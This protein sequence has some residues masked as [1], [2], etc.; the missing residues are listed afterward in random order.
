MSY[1]AENKKAF[2]DYEILEKIEAGLS[3]T[4]QETKSAKNGQVSLK[5]AFVTFHGP[6]AFITNMNIAKYAAAGPLPEYD[7]TR[8]R[9]LL[10]RKKEIDYLRGK[11]LEQGLTIVPLR[12][13]T[14]NCFVKIEIAVARGKKRFDKRETLKKRDAERETRRAMKN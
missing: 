10:L 8:S 12:V 11:A 5:G 1:L 2:F 13:Y 4:G 9:P 3:L 6:S 7:P 14:K